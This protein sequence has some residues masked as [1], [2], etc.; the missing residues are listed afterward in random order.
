MFTKAMDALEKR[1]GI[2]VRYMVQGLSWLTI[3]QIATSAS[4][5]VLAIAFANLV[6]PEVY[7][8]YRYVLAVAGI[9]AIP[10]LG[11]INAALIQ[12]IAG[13]KEETLTRALKTKLQWGMLGSLAALVGSAYYLINDNTVLA[14]SFAVVAVFLP[15]MEAYNLFDSLLQGRKDFMR[16]SIINGILQIIAALGI[17]SA[18]L[19]SKDVVV[20]ISVYFAFW[21][22]GRFLAWHYVK[23]HLGPP[24]GGEDT[25]TI[26]FGIHLSIMSAATVV[27]QYADRVIL[28]QYIG[29]AEV[30]IYSIAIAIPE[31]FKNGIKNIFALLLPRYST[32]SEKS[33]RADI[34][35]KAGL[36]AVFTLFIT[37]VYIVAV[38]FVFPIFFPAY[39]EAILYSQIFALSFVAVV[40]G[41]FTTAQQALHKTRSLYIYNIA[42]PILQIIAIVIGIFFMGIMGA[43]LA[44]V[45][46]RLVM[47]A[48][49]VVLY[50]K[51]T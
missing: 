1:L 47:L 40:A 41:I 31:Q 24:Q 13:G 9:L 23:K 46:T 26:P 11:G 19:L 4:A 8:T 42:S 18:L 2:D 16:S 30:A 27:A 45:V 20:L 34:W 22:L 10:A 38:P 35:K 48:V 44:R 32:Q 50:V 5:L 6:S 7:G 33:I 28:F 21:T 39:H 36:L 15:T 17:I 14:A 51:D 43:I 25:R 49:S 37:A 12:A 3:G 29:A